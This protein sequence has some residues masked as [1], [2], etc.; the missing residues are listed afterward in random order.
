MKIEKQIGYL[1]V[2]G[3][4]AVIIPYTLLTIIFSYPDILRQ[5]TGSILT[6]FHAGGSKLILTWLGFALSGL[7]L[8]AAYSLLGQHLE[9]KLPHVRWITSVGIIS[10]IVQI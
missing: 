3:A 10:G 2:F 1:L 9:R 4:A 6:Q 8:I 5:E 7:P